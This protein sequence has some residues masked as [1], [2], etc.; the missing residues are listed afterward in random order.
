MGIQKPLSINRGLHPG[1]RGGALGKGVHPAGEPQKAAKRNTLP[2]P[3]P[4][5][6]QGAPSRAAGMGPWFCPWFLP[7][8]REDQ[9][10]R[11]VR[12]GAA[13]EPGHSQT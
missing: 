7:R 12:E 2:Q 10:G 5:R 6:N 11:E 3:C 13:K 4:A 8:K 1:F 9:G